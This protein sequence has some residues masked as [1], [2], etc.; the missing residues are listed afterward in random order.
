MN[1]C[2]LCYCLRIYMWFANPLLSPTPMNYF[3]WHV[4]THSNKMDRIAFNIISCLRCWNLDHMHSYVNEVLERLP[5]ISRPS[6]KSWF[7]T[8]HFHVQSTYSCLLQTRPSAWSSQTVCWTN[9]WIWTMS[10]EKKS[11]SVLKHLWI[12]WGCKK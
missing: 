6:Y 1:N 12:C 5:Y 3:Y 4:T 7:Y 9:F 2:L 11:H 8:N 10:T